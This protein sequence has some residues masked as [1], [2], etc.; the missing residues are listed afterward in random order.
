MTSIHFLFPS[1]FY[2]W[3][4]GLVTTIMYGR[5][6]LYLLLQYLTVVGRYTQLLTYYYNI[7]W[8]VYSP[9]FL[10][11]LYLLVWLRNHNILQKVY[12]ALNTTLPCVKSTQICY[13]NILCR[14]TQPLLLQHITIHLHK[15]GNYIILNLDKPCYHNII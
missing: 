2:K 12:T 15:S 9:Q 13:Y 5:S 10:L 11:L 14:S 8:Q 6:T 1:L 7:V 3:D 4:T